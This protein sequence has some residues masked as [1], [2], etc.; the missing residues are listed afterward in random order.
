MDVSTEQYKAAITLS[1]L[2][3]Y[4]LPDLTWHIG[5]SNHLDGQVPHRTE[6]VREVVY[7]WAKVLECGV[8]ED[9]YDDYT[10]VRL[11]TNYGDYGTFI[12]IWGHADRA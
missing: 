7:E 3:M 5:Q 11:T 1:N 2:T 6:D 10:A 8:D 12:K 9:E 4:G